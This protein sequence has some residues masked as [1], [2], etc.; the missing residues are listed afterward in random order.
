MRSKYCYYPHCTSKETKIQG[1][2]GYCHQLTHK[3]PQKKSLSGINIKNSEHFIT[4]LVV[5]CFYLILFC[6]NIYYIYAI[7]LTTDYV[8]FLMLT[9]RNRRDESRANLGRVLLHAFYTL[10]SLFHI[11]SHFFSLHINF[12]WSKEIYKYFLKP[13]MSILGV[14]DVDDWRW[15]EVITK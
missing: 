3:I 10:T 15:L 5:F 4:A 14:E 2:Q 8:S 12:S 7:D 9:T 6:C 1:S 13:E 11:S